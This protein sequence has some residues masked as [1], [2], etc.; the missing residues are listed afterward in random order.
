[1]SVSP[2]LF[3]Q[4]AGEAAAGGGAASAI[5][6][7]IAILLTIGFAIALF[8]NALQARPEVGAELELAANRKPYLSD[9]EL[10]GKKLDRT[11]GAALVLLAAISVGLPLY[12]LYEPARQEGAVE[13]FEELAVRYG[14]EI[15]E[16]KSNCAACH[17]PEGVGG[18]AQTSLL[19][20]NGQF[21]Q[22]VSWQ[23]PALNTVLY[24]YSRD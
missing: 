16:T 11:L 1:M 7:T 17:G 22:Q 6:W 9:E 21:V 14:K 12:W 19:N 23:A 2:T 24:R 18:V 20:D 15:Y 4:E 3:A 5:G 13:H 8:L 10:E